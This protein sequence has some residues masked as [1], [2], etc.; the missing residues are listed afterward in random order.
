MWRWFMTFVCVALAP[1]TFAAQ[2]WAQWRGPERNGRSSEK[3]LLQEWPR[4]G[5]PLVWS[6]SNLGSGY[7]SPAVRGDRLYLVENDGL[8]S[9]S[10]AAFS[11]VDGARVWKTSIGKVGN[12]DQLPSYPSARSTPTVDRD[13]VFA[14]G[15]DGDLVSLDAA[16][17]A[18]RWKLSLRGA[19]GG[20]PGTWG[21][22]ESPLVDGDSVIVTPVGPEATMVA[23]DRE[24][25]AVRWKAVVPEA[26]DAAYASTV[27]VRAGGRKMYVQLLPS[28]IFGIDASDGAF[29]WRSG[30][31]AQGRANVAT[32]V[33]CGDHIYT[34]LPPVGGAVLQLSASAAGVQTKRL[35]VTRGLP[36]AIGGAVIHEDRIYGTNA[37]GMVAADLLTGKI[38]WQAPSVG[39]GSILYADRRLYVRGENGEVA[40]VEA[41][42]TAYRERGRFTPPDPPARDRDQAWTYPV[43]ADGRLYLR[44]KSRLWVYDVRAARRDRR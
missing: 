27:I 40:L 39:P 16:T 4:E 18:V 3:D 12:P 17:G 19:F 31:V 37:D 13:R 28:G 23:L 41:D 21:Y 32:P 11:A 22:A 29:V 5:P 43:L 34:S 24:T 7:G 36:N 20:R 2:D 6:I 30:E 9:E 33:A 15:S 42:A 14:L 44:D 25:G 35:H 38:L 8:E 10:V 26:Q 1:A